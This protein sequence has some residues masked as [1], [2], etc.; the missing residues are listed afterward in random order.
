[1]HKTITFRNYSPEPFFTED[2]KKVREFLSRINANKLYTPRMLWGAWEWAVTH[3]GRDQANLGRMGLWEDNGKLVA[4][5][6]YECPLGE[7]Y[8]MVDE[9]YAYL[10]PD[11]VAYAKENLHDNGK[12]R[13]IL[14][15]GDSGFA[16][17]AAAQ[18]FRPTQRKE[19]M[20]V[21]DIDML[22]EYAL[23]GG[24]SF[25]S[26]A[27]GWD[28]HQYNRVM[29]RG[30]NQDRIGRPPYDDE[31][32]AGRKQMLSSPMINPE[33]VM[34][35]A[36]PDGNYVSHCTM[37]YSPGDF[38]CYVEPVATDFEYRKLGL[39]KAVVLEAIRRCGA[40]GARQAVVGSGQQFYY[41]IGFYPACGFTHWEQPQAKDGGEA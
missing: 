24:Y 28:W 15:D 14:P 4:V 9:D 6:A 3:S 34:A 26:M 31:S 33:L 10:K 35:V 13:L 5:A 41:S 12:L 39:G 22:Q 16:Q 30:F 36:A 21:L 38:Y 20:S 11:M 40:F 7:G 37:W 8:L 23:P 19:H 18:G 25:V 32:I 17:A 29:W 27:D 2:Y 1:M